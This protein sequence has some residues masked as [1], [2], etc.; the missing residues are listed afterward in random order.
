MCQHNCQYLKPLLLL[1]Y[2]DKYILCDPQ[3]FI[4]YVTLLYRN[5][6]LSLLGLYYVNNIASS[7]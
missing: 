2:V 6:V 3:Y 1:L 4:I 5:P 7:S